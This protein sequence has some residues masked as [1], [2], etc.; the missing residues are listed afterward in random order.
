MRFRSLVF[1][2]P[3]VVFVLSF[4]FS[5]SRPTRLRELNF[6]R[7]VILIIVELKLRFIPPR[8]GGGDV[9]NNPIK[10]R[11]LSKIFWLVACTFFA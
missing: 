5:L 8:V 7:F 6:E 4:S 3:L 2:V 9:E 1:G 10:L 11:K